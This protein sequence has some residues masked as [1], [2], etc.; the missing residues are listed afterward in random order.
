MLKCVAMSKVEAEILQAFCR[1]RDKEE[2]EI[3]EMLK[4]NYLSDDFIKE[5]FRLCESIAK[6]RVT[7]TD[8]AA[9]LKFS[10]EIQ[11]KVTADVM[12]KYVSDLLESIEDYF[13][14]SEH[15]KVMLANAEEVIPSDEGIKELL[16]N[17]P[18]MEM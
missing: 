2:N 16:K 11:K 14:A 6:L 7:L 9:H 12:G 13:V 15:I 1:M 4:T 17:T 8:K 18:T 5:A 3:K 10:P